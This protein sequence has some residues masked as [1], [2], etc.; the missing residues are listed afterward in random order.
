MPVALRD[1][2]LLDWAGPIGQQAMMTGR[3]PA[4]PARRV[5]SPGSLVRMRS[6][7]AASSTTVASMAFAVPAAP[8]EAELPLG[9]GDLGAGERAVFGL[10]TGA[11]YNLTSVGPEGIV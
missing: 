10:P 4:A 9:T 5:R 2:I 1:G 7:G 11:Q 3:F 6:P 8:C